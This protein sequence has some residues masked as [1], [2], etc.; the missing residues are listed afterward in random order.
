M[1]VQ[2]DCRCSC[3]MAT[4]KRLDATEGMMS[5]LL[6]ENRALHEM[7]QIRAENQVPVIA[8]PS[9]V[10]LPRVV[11]RSVVATN[12]ESHVDKGGRSSAKVAAERLPTTRSVGLASRVANRKQSWLAKGFLLLEVSELVTI[13]FGSV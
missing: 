8:V 2:A 13:Y 7:L 10:L 3:C 12:A 6:Q 5:R 11:E 9:V 4:Y 1:R